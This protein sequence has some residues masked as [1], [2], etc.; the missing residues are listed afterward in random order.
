MSI[1]TNI[2]S[3]IRSKLADS[4]EDIGNALCLLREAEEELQ[5]DNDQGAILCASDALE[6]ISGLAENYADLAAKLAIW[7]EH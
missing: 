2:P 6:L 5:D 7:S 1:T 4:I 3:A